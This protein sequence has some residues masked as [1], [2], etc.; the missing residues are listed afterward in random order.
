MGF[1][2]LDDVA[3]PRILGN[4]EVVVALFL[5]AVSVRNL[6]VGAAAVLGGVPSLST[7]RRR[8]LRVAHQNKLSWR[9]C[10]NDSRYLEALTKRPA[11]GKRWTGGKAGGYEKKTDSCV[12]I[13]NGSGSRGRRMVEVS[14]LR[15]ASV[16]FKPLASATANS[17]SQPHLATEPTSH[18]TRC[19]AALNLASQLQGWQTGDSAEQHFSSMLGIYLLEYSDTIQGHDYRQATAASFLMDNTVQHVFRETQSLFPFLF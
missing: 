7:A 11:I 19:V 8:V 5:E 17:P 9:A 4:S 12:G 10:T 14:S 18:C 13:E 6:G 16:G 3:V 2:D 1:A 15:C